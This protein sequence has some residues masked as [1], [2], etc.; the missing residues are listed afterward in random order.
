MGVVKISSREFRQGKVL[1][2]DPARGVAIVEVRRWIDETMILEISL[3]SGATVLEV[4]RVREHEELFTL[5][6]LDT[7]VL[8]WNREKVYVQCLFPDDSLPDKNPWGSYY[9]RMVIKKEIPE[10][11]L[12]FLNDRHLRKRRQEDFARQACRSNMFSAVAGAQESGIPDFTPYG[13]A[14]CKRWE[15]AVEMILFQVPLVVDY[16]LAVFYPS[17]IHPRCHVVAFFEVSWSWGERLL[18]RGRPP[19]PDQLQY[20]YIPRYPLLVEVVQ[21]DLPLLYSLVTTDFQEEVIILDWECWQE[22][23]PFEE[24]WELWE[25]N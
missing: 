1:S 24:L 11:G 20:P 19:R 5:N 13:E 17:R 12:W 4:E 2:I 3:F 10:T 9:R 7:P 21:V 6:F 16:V 15:D 18:G 14:Y 8:M 23:F 25:D 22:E